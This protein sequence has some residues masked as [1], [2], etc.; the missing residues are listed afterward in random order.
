MEMRVCKQLL[1]FTLGVVAANN[2]KPV[3]P[4]KSRVYQS[5]QRRAGAPPLIIL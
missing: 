3:P 1:G 5:S 4:K 2:Y